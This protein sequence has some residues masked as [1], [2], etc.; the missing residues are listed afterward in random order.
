MG[1]GWGEG[2]WWGGGRYEWKST[3]LAQLLVCS[4]LLFEP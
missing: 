3:F 1:R 4:K 2:G